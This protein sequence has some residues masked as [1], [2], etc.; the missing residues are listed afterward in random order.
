MKNKILPLIIGIL[1]GAIIASAGFIIYIKTNNLS[2]R[3]DFG[4]KMPQMN[5]SQ[6]ANKDGR[7]PPDFPNGEKPSNFPSDKNQ[8]GK[9]ENETN[10]QNN[11]QTQKTN[12]TQNNTSEN[13][14]KDFSRRYC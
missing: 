13:K 3:P 6:D 4:G 14:Q 11:N 5:Q 1:I 7:T 2:K 12:Q 9:S 8:D 10:T